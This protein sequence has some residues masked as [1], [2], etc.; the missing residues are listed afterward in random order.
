MNAEPS[1]WN[2]PLTASGFAG[3]RDSVSTKKDNVNRSRDRLTLDT[4]AADDQVKEAWLVVRANDFHPVEQ[5]IRFADDRQLDFEELVF[6]IS[7]PQGSSSET[8]APAQIA[9]G[10]P[11]KA[12]ITASEATVD[13]NETELELRYNLNPA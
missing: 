7:A 6:E 11:A 12:S 9:P 3:W 2:A 10:S 8:A 1:K 4:T 13:P 5:H